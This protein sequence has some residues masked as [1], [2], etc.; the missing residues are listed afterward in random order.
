[1][2]EVDKQADKTRE[3]IFVFKLLVMEACACIERY[4]KKYK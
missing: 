2:L 3:E 1:M 4:K